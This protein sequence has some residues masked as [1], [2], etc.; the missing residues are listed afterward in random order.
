[1]KTATK[2]ITY[3]SS[4]DGTG[5]MYA[6]IALAENA[7]N[8]PL[9]AVMPGFHG[10]K[11]LIRTVIE[12]LAQ[13]GLCA[14]GIDMRGR[15]DSAG[16]KDAGGIEIHDIVD[17]MN[18]ACTNFPRAIDKNAWHILGYSGGGGNVLSAITKFPGRFIVA[19]SFFGMSDYELWYNTTPS[20]ECKKSMEEWIG[21]PPDRFPQQYQARSSLRA[22]GNAQW[23]DVH[24][25][26][27]EE[28]LTCPEPM[29]FLF[30]INSS[31]TRCRI[32]IP[33]TT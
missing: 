11:A 1:M 33:R 27:D 25:F 18:T 15:G 26:W 28:E 8:L 24:L 5:P 16:H 13:K 9:V 23:T 19:V 2:T 30:N 6:D 3:F 29:N 12:R 32:G 31:R 10:S 20:A 7:Q 22:A 14:I 17:A 21:G 4:V